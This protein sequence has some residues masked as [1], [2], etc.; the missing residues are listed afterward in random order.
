M[1]GEPPGR[2]DMIRDGFDRHGH[3]RWIP[4]YLRVPYRSKS[5]SDAAFLKAWG[6]T[7]KAKHERRADAALRARGGWI[8]RK[9]GCFYDPTYSNV[10]LE[11][12]RTRQFDPSAA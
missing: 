1:S 10:N 2:R 8:D 11:P 6:S 5:L 3:P 4:A 12:I 7:T 9:H